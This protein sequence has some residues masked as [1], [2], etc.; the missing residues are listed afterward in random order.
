MSLV[1]PFVSVGGTRV[2]NASL[3]T[4]TG[5]SQNGPCATKNPGQGAG[6]FIASRVPVYGTNRLVRSTFSIEP[7]IKS[8]A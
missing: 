5:D 7:T 6:V 3:V 8:N 2:Q 1:K 4:T